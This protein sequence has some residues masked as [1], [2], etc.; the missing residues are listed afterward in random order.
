MK[1]GQLVRFKLCSRQGVR[2]EKRD[3]TLCRFSRWSMT[4]RAIVFPSINT[5][6]LVASLALA[7]EGAPLEKHKKARERERESA[8]EQLKE[9]FQQARA[10]G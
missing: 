6:A 4:E 10:D 7:E 2:E 1:L 5:K 8:V 9:A 3:P